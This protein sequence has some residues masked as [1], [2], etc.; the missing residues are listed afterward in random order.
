M[1]KRVLSAAAT[2]SLLAIPATLFAAPASKFLGDAIK[3]DNSEMTLGALAAKRGASSEVRAFGRM[4]QVDHAK[5]KTSAVVAARRE[6]VSVS[7]GMMPEASAE[8]SKLQHLSGRAFDREFARYMVED[9][10]KDIAEF[11]KQER[12]G[13]RVTALLARQTLPHLRK[14][15]ATAQG[16]RT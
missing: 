4:L 3:G 2:I 10:Q 12:T 15:L 16:I 14:H 5:A 7:S 1:N 13:D 8:F 11:R 9:H 6:R